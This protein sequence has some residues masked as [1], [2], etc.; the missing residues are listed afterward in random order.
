M[1][2]FPVVVSVAE[3]KPDQLYFIARGRPGR[4]M[5]YS[6]YLSGKCAWSVKP[7]IAIQAYGGEQLVKTFE[8][9]KANGIELVAVEVP[10]DASKRWR[11]RKRRF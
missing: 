6:R 5:F 3:T 8:K 1:N 4:F 7:G 10:A 9:N 2:A 11:A